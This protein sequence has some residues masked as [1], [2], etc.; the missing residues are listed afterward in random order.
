MGFD[1][2]VNPLFWC[3]WSTDINTQTHTS[4]CLYTESIKQVYIHCQ[5]LIINGH[6]ASSNIDWKGVFYIMNM[7]NFFLL[8]IKQL[9]REQKGTI[10][11]AIFLN[12]L[13]FVAWVC[14][15]KQWERKEPIMSSNYSP[16]LNQLFGG[17]K[18]I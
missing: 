6:C 8:K 12:C 4:N 10:W 17:I 11:T 3:W 16:I 15:S 1:C 5:W 13:L 2:S 9:Y 18:Q 7:S 14:I